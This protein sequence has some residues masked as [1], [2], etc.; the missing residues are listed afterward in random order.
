MGGHEG[1]GTST[2]KST[3]TWK[4]LSVV[5]ERIKGNAVGRGVLWTKTGTAREMIESRVRPGHVGS[6]VPHT[7]PQLGMSGA[8]VV[9]QTSISASWRIGLACPSRR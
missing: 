1:G 5:T 4:A 7:A 9:S 3:S 2:W 8:C 6:L